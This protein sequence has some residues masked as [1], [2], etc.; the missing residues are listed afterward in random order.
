MNI[1]VEFQQ[2]IASIAADLLPDSVDAVDIDACRKRIAI[3]PPRDPKHGDMATNAA[4]VLARFI[5]EPPRTIAEKI[6]AALEQN[7]SIAG[8]EI[9]GPGFVNWNLR[10]ARWLQTLETILAAPED[11]GASGFGSGR[12]VNVEY[13]SANP[14]GPLHI[15]HARGAVVGDVLASLLEHTGHKVVREYYINDAG[16]QVALLGQSLHWRYCEALG[17][18]AGAMPEGLYPGDYLKPAAQ[19][20]VKAHGDDYAS[21]PA[22]SVHNSEIVS[23]FSGAAVKHMM[24][25][26]RE[27]LA[28]LGVKHTQFSSERALVES[29][30]VDAVFAQLEQKGFLYRAVPPLPKG[31]ART[32]PRDTR[33]HDMF[34]SSRFG[35]D[36]D[37]PL[38]K[39]DGA[40]TYFAP[41]IAYH[42]E[43]YQRG[44]AWLI[45]IL[46]ADHGGYA[47]RM[48]AALKALVGDAVQFDALICQTVHLKEKNQTLRMSK[49]RGNFVRLRE[50]I[51]D[52]GADSVRYFLLMRRADAP[53]EF[54]LEHARQHN[55]DNP[56]YYVQYAHARCC[57]LFRQACQVTGLDAAKDTKPMQSA[58]LSL[59]TDASTFSL[60][61]A[62]G[63]WPRLIEQAARRC[64]PHRVAFG[65]HELAS[66]FHA[67]WNEGH[68]RP[69][70]R[71]VQADNHEQTQARLLLAFGVRQVLRNGMRL[72]GVSAPEEI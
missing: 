63:R 45:D 34:C 54:D 9:A 31:G 43:K 8:A 57:A 42:Y 46:G 1:F 40:W 37:R 18:A 70:L 55:R 51:D 21:H 19:A 59:L 66:Q 2:E 3:E 6:K 56:V 38:R 65:L 26:I 39:P 50:L 69:E 17:V 41:D 16:R 15:G 4:L 71:F 32:E 36:S 11:Y 22:G 53:L 47:P 7:P 29:R 64:E 44:A 24:E 33:P 27:D 20:M 35:D 13:V 25:L 52:I 30:S 72:L 23:L 14:T 68:S 5:E 58:N 28:L 60:V 48:R 62:L 49:R 61:R 12:S 10:P 67:L